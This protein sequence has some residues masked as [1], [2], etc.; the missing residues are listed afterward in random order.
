MTAEARRPPNQLPRNWELG[1]YPLPRRAIILSWGAIQDTTIQPEASAC[2]AAA[3]MRY[4]VDAPHDPPHR[5]R[6]L[7]RR[8]VQP[9][10]STGGASRALAASGAGERAPGRA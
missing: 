8:P 4:I 7:P 2:D 5:L 3:A 6:P 1:S 9:D 10:R